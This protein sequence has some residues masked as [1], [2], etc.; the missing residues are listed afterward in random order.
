MREPHGLTVLI[1]SA[2]IQARVRDLANAIRRTHPGGPLVVIGVLKG[3]FVFV[4]D[5]VREL[6]DLDVRVDFLGVRSYAGT[7]STGTVAFTH[8]LG[9]DI[10]DQHCLLVEDIVDTGRTLVFLTQSLGLRRPASLT[11]C[12]L[13]DKPSRREVTVEADLVGFTIPDR[14]VVGYGLDVDQRLRH[15]DHVAIY[16]PS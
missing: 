9:V 4:A 7:T 11:V 13:L 3:S 1:D 6:G 15:L 8:D 14:F 2:A 12:A 16:D 10:T 5:L